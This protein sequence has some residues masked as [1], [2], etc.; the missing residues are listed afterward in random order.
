M[1]DTILKILP[2]RK[3]AGMLIRHDPRRSNRLEFVRVRTARFNLSA[4]P[5]A[6]SEEGELYLPEDAVPA[7]VANLTGQTLAG[8]TLNTQPPA[9][10]NA[11]KL[12]PDDLTGLDFAMTSPRPTAARS[13]FGVNIGEVGIGHRVILAHPDSEIS[14]TPPPGAT[15]IT[16]EVGINPAAYTPDVTSVTDGVS[17]T[18]F[19]LR[20]DGL[21]RVLYQRDLDPVKVPSDRGP[22]QISL[23]AAG[24]FTGPVIFKISPGE[25]NS[26]LNDWAY[27]G[28][29]EIR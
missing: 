22:Q 2:P 14:F 10:P 24:P 5:F 23:D 20:A 28:R 29:I 17:V 19:E 7:T 25:K 8:V 3:I 26:I 13:M 18:I 12:K 1:L 27:W 15:R 21:R 9:D 6:T 16:A 11:D 4:A